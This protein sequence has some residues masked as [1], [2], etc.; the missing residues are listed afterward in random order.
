M[1]ACALYH[2][3]ID[4]IGAVYDWNALFD[5]FPGSVSTN[6]YR[7]IWLIVAVVLWIT[8]EK[9]DRQRYKSE[10][11]GETDDKSA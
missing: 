6:V 7:G 11:V 4:A 8:A 3:F 10:F 1:I 9:K 2:T 5:G